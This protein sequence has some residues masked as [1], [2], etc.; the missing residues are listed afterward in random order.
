MKRRSLRCPGLVIYFY[1]TNQAADRPD[2]VHEFRSGVKVAGYHVGGFGDARLPVTL[3][4]GTYNGGKE[5]R[6][7][8]DFLSH[9]D[10]FFM[11]G[12]GWIA[13]RFRLVNIEIGIL[14]VAGVVPFGF[15]VA[16]Q[17]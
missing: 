12:S 6:R 1:P 13:R 4:V 2:C 7:Q 5:S 8:E 9:C 16:N 3:C 14:V 10:L 11:P 17:P 15:Q